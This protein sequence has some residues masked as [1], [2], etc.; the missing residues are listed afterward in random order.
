MTRTIHVAHSPDSDDA[1]MFYALAA[2]KLEEALARIEAGLSHS[3][4]L[5]ALGPRFDDRVTGVLHIHA[6][7]YSTRPHIG[8]AG[9]N[10]IKRGQIPCGIPLWLE[11]EAGV[12]GLT[13]THLHDHAWDASLS[14]RY[15]YLAGCHVRQTFLRTIG[16]HVQQRLE[17]ALGCQRQPRHA[18]PAPQPVAAGGRLSRVHP[19]E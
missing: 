16:R 17:V 3:D 4:L 9:L 18:I 6:K 15:T 10:V 12:I 14:V 8:H 5:I 13:R 7:P 11:A 1:F 2:G 19:E